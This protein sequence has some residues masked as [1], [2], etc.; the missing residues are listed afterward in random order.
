MRTDMTLFN[1][2]KFGSDPELFVRHKKSGKI[3]SVH[4]MIPGTKEKPYKVPKGAIQVDGVAAEFN[5]DPASNLEEWMENHATVIKE[6][7]HYM[8]TTH[9]LVYEPIAFFDEEY[10]K[11][12]PPETQA[13]G[14]TPDYNAWT[15]KQNPSPNAHQLSGDEGIMRTASGHIHIGWTSERSVDDEDH[16]R[17]CFDLV[18]L[19]DRRLT[20]PLSTA[21]PERALK[22]MDAK[23]RSLYGKAG[24]CRVKPYGVEIRAPSNMWLTRDFFRK[25]AFS[26]SRSV[27]VAYFMGQTLSK[28]EEREIFERL[29]G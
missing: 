16:R 8:G 18:K 11:T 25:A 1:T 13:L 17:R 10:F 26:F 27:A 9:E 28:Q 6:L 12:L 4:N 2:L 21:H 19:S 15:G 29:T 23:R 14:C 5:I 24:A 20:Y 3:V 7:E 22:D